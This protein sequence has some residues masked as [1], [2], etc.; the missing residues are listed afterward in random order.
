MEPSYFA[1][2][3]AAIACVVVSLRWCSTVLFC[4]VLRV[5][6]ALGGRIFWV[7]VR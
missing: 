3:M 7:R 5:L 4:L 1:E 2:E 6:I